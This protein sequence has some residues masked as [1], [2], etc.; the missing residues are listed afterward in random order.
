MQKERLKKIPLIVKCYRL[1]NMTMNLLFR[2]NNLIM[3]Y[4]KGGILH[5][6][7]MDIDWSVKLYDCNFKIASGGGFL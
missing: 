5:K 7:H 2:H 1:Y 6:Y 4:I 3:C